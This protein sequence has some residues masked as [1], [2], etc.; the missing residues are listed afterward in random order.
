MFI[1]RISDLLPALQDD[2]GGGGGAPDASGQPVGDAAKP[3]ASFPDEKS[4]MARLNR[5]GQSQMLAKAKE[6]GFES[7]A[8]MEASINAE[9][10]FL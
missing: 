3:F 6:L 1:P 2:Q 10:L 5:E 9:V 4:F 8:D 7:V